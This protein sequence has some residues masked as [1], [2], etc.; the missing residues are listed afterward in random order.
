MFDGLVY[1]PPLPLYYYHYNAPVVR[2]GRKGEWEEPKSTCGALALIST[3]SI[4][5]QRKNHFSLEPA[6]NKHLTSQRASE[7]VEKD[8]RREA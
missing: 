6:D 1:Y 5:Y 3:S 4:R 8:L 7:F 2:G